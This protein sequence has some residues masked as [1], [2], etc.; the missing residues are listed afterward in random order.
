MAAVMLERDFPTCKLLLYNVSENVEPVLPTQPQFEQRS[1]VVLE[2]R[3]DL[4]QEKEHLV[5]D[6]ESVAKS[7]KILTENDLTDS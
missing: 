2:R 7:A 1:T 6:Y 4:G 3:D 5:T